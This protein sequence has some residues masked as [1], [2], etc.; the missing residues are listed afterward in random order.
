MIYGSQN[1]ICKPSWVDANPN[2]VSTCSMLQGLIL[3][4]FCVIRA[5]QRSVQM[6][7]FQRWMELESVWVSRGGGSRSV[8]LCGNR[9]VARDICCKRSHTT[10][11]TSLRNSTTITN[12]N[13]L[14]IY[15]DSSSESNSESHTSS[16][17][18]QTDVE[19]FTLLFR[20]WHTTYFDLLFL[21]LLYGIHTIHRGRCWCCYRRG[22][23]TFGYYTGS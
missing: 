18:K 2:F 10:S 11:N 13:V 4:C 14:T 7:L 17:L 19:C 20:Q 21:C 16:N 23:R 1:W 9:M 22:R 5:I 8:W 12:E 6:A 3:H 15:H